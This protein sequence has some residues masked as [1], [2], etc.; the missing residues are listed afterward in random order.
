MGQPVQFASCD[1]KGSGLSGRSAQIGVQSE[2]NT[3]FT[4]SLTKRQQQIHC[5]FS[6]S[7]SSVAKVPCGSRKPLTLSSEVL[8]KKRG[9][10]SEHKCGFDQTTQL[11]KR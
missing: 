2:A 6:R 11:H 5:S 10:G 4:A 7:S 8:L 9:L 3:S 1:Y